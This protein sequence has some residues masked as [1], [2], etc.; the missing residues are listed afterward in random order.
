MP[1]AT[2]TPAD[3]GDRVTI[4]TETEWVVRWNDGGIVPCGTRDEAVNVARIYGYG[5]PDSKVSVQHRTVTMTYGPWIAEPDEA[6][7]G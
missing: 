3:D 2:A 5:T 6:S 7:H 1:G 4:E